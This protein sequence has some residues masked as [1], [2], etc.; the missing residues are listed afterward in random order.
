LRQRSTHGPP[1]A[2][3]LYDSAIAESFPA[4]FQSFCARACV[5]RGVEQQPDITI[6]ENGRSASVSLHLKFPADLALQ[7]ALAVTERI[8]QAI[9]ARPGVGE[10][11][12]HLEPLEH[13]LSA[14][15]APTSTDLDAIREIK[16]IVL[17]LTGKEPRGAKLLRTE[18]GRVIFLTLGVGAETSLVDARGCPAWRR[19]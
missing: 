7:E 15:P 6:F 10:V 4:S 12:T 1:F 3:F 14:S 2:R 8:E 18:A 16:R 13:P 11:Q 19:T 17:E 5:P 9:R